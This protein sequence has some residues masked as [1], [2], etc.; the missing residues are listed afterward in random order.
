VEK[1]GGVREAENEHYIDITT[2]PVV[3]SMALLATRQE[4]LTYHCV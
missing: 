1:T 4:I 3:S 2:T